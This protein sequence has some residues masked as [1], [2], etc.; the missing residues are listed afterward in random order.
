MNSFPT[1]QSLRHSVAVWPQVSG[2]RAQPKGKHDWK[3][4]HKAA[5]S[6]VTIL[7]YS[8][9][10]HRSR[11][12]ALKAFRDGQFYKQHQRPQSSKWFLSL[13]QGWA[14]FTLQVGPGSTGT[15]L[16][17]DFSLMFFVLSTLVHVRRGKQRSDL[18]PLI[19][20]ITDYSSCSGT[21]KT[22]G[23]CC[24]QEHNFTISVYCCTMFF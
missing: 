21:E 9:F 2:V 13:G 20:L 10:W 15:V 3:G 7:S 16:M 6:H 23:Q 5:R 24:S 8:Y 17:Q 12:S 18:C 4:G 1:G 22:L 11:C 14:T 19:P